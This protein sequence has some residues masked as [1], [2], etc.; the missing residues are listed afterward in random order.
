MKLDARLVLAIECAITAG[1]C[2]QAAR[3]TTAPANWQAIAE[4]EHAEASGLLAAYCADLDADTVRRVMR[5][6]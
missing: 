4:Q 5:G 1:A 6:S 3:M 2:R